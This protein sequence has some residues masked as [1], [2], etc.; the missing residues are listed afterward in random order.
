MILEAGATSRAE[1]IRSTPRGLYVTSLMGFGFNPVTGDFSQANVAARD[2]G[3]S[4]DRP[5][6]R[7]SLWFI[8]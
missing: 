8:C 2:R 6:I 4:T 7:F 1:I 5:D 3:P